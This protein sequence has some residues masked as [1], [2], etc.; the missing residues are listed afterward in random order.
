MRITGKLSLKLKKHKMRKKVN[1]KRR[2]LYLSISMLCSWIYYPKT[3][4]ILLGGLIGQRIFINSHIKTMEN[5][6]KEDLDKWICL[7]FESL[8]NY[9]DSGYNP[10][11]AWSR[12]LEQVSKRLEGEDRRSPIAENFCRE[13]SRSIERRN[14]G[15]AMEENLDL[16]SKN[17]N[18]KYFS[19]FLK[20]F[21]LG[22]RQG[23]D[24]AALTEN[25]LLIMNDR[26]DL[27]QERE[28]KLYAAKREQLMLF[29][30]PFILLLC[31]RTGSM[32]SSQSGIFDFIIRMV[33]LPVF[34]LAYKWSEEILSYANFD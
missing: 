8:S 30:M 26:R 18:H 9:L 20:H 16:L 24:L 33:C 15:W 13:V 34:Y 22:T 5:K 2:L 19:S 25:F 32:I 14:E 1:I 7:F 12:S 27:R 11:A 6:E 4:F 10:F 21:I 28:T 23:A 29:A 17:L 3:I 31:M